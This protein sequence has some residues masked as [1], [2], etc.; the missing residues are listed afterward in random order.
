VRSG[1]Q[2]LT[3]LSTHRN[4]LVLRALAEGSQRQG[5]L[6]RVTGLPAQTTLRATLKGLEGIGAIVK[7]R[8]NAFPGTLDYELEKPGEELLFVAA[9]LERWLGAAP[10]GPLTLGGDASKAAIKALAEGWS[11]SMLRALAAKPLSLTELD[12]VIA[13]LNYPSLERR[14]GALR[15][16]GLVEALPA[17]GR[18]TPY[19]VTECLRRGM[20]PLVAAIRW[21]RRHAPDRTAPLGRL[22]VEAGFLLTLPMLP[23]PADV[24]GQ[25]RLAVELPNGAK[26]LLAGVIV[27]LKAGRVSS[28]TSRLEGHPAAWISGPPSAWLEAV[29]DADA[30]GLELGGDCGLARSLLDG[31]HTTLFRGQMQATP[32]VSKQN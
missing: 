7:C 24:S 12:R 31:L 16:A 32:P 2:T 26:R 30:D 25:C 15:L 23:L 1:A 8:R 21:E 5:E 6:R 28:C 13:D 9:A 17:N 10:G 3:L 29:I 18:G 4:V 27:E 19:A 20:A 11:S 14:L 22:D